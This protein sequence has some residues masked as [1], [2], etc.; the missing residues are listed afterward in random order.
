LRKREK[1]LKERERERERERELRKREREMTCF[2]L[3]LL[4]HKLQ[5]YT[6]YIYNEFPYL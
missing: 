2:H 1:E 4:S 5:R 6:V 3:E